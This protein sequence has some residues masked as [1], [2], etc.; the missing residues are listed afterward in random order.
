M[1]KSRLD[2]HSVFIKRGLHVVAVLLTLQLF[3]CT[4]P[5]IQPVS[6]I[7]PVQPRVETPVI[8]TVAERSG[9]G[10]TGRTQE[11]AVSNTVAVNPANL[12]HSTILDEG[13]GGTGVTASGF[14]GTGIVGTI[15]QFG[16]IWVNGIEIGLG[17]KTEISSNLTGLSKT[18]KPNDLRIGQQVWLETRPNQEKTTTAAIHVYYPLAGKIDEITSK[19][20]AT[21]IL[22]NGQRVY[23]SS[24]T[25]MSEQINLYVGEYVRIS[26]LPIFLEDGIQRSNAWQATLIEPNETKDTW[27]TRVPD[28]SFSD[29]V[30]RVI[31]HDSWSTA[32]QNG[33]FK[34]V[35]TGLSSQPKIKM[36]GEEASHPSLKVTKPQ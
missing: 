5:K 6:P 16:S 9:F 33:E 2:R 35:S 13:F 24:Q 14:G 10:G 4:T 32:Y 7:E 20:M 11:D 1:I 21:E 27:F 29:K 28:V 30:N 22:V 23:I 15:E 3:G 25:V 34:A 18:L 26:G 12:R 8:E 17:Q 36:V 31:M 19:D